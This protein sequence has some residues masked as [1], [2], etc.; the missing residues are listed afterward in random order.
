MQQTTYVGEIAEI[1]QMMSQSRRSSQVTTA[2]N[3]VNV[4]SP[5]MTV[6]QKLNN[7]LVNVSQNMLNN[8]KQMVKEPVVEPER[9][10]NMTPEERQ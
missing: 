6:S 5:R 7:N 2:V 4:H 10:R 9:E 1:N 8:T 3:N